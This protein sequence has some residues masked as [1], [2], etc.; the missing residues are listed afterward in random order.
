MFPKE[1]T[2][3]LK[4]FYAVFEFFSKIGDFQRH[5]LYFFEENFPPRRKFADRQKFEGGSCFPRSA[6]NSFWHV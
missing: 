1:E 6:T 5:F 4:I 2:W 3:M